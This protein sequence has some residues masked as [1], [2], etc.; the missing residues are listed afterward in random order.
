MTPEHRVDREQGVAERPEDV[1][2]D[3]PNWY[4]YMQLRNTQRLLLLTALTVFWAVLAL[5]TVAITGDGWPAFVI[6]ALGLGVTALKH[7]A[8][9]PG[10]ARALLERLGVPTWRHPS[11]F[12]GVDGLPPGSS[13][14]STDGGQDVEADR[15]R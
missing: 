3:V 14:I 2:A 7:E 10:R 13:E 6:A 8:E 15:G 4:I 12:R 5:S 1:P 9:T 11:E